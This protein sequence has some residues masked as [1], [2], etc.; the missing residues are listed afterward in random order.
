M[1]SWQ[2]K[3]DRCPPS[4]PPLHVLRHRESDITGHRPEWRHNR[5]HCTVTSLSPSF[6]PCPPSCPPASDS[7]VRTSAAC[8]VAGAGVSS[9]PSPTGSLLRVRIQVIWQVVI[10][11]EAHLVNSSHAGEQS[12][13]A[14]PRVKL[15]PRLLAAPRPQ[16]CLEASSLG[17]TGLS[18][19]GQVT[20]SSRSWCWWPHVH[21][22][23]GMPLLAC[24]L[25]GYGL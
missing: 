11:S 6:W 9:L 16:P 14:V 2:V 18:R 5:S 19:G 21:R 22:V 7:P 8:P 3:Q 17:L 4:S 13:Q 10:N 24:C 20:A 12:V 23:P 1:Q 15:R 25:G